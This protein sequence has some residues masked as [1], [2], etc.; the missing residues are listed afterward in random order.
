MKSGKI[1]DIMQLLGTILVY[2]VLWMP[3][4]ILV[5]MSFSNHAIGLR[6]QGFTLQWYV[7]VFNT[8]KA[9][10]ALKNSL[11][12]S[13]VTTVISTI[14]GTLAAYG[15]YKYKFRGRGAL[16]MSVLLPITIPYVVTA[17]TLLI[18]FTQ[19]ARVDWTLEEASA[20]LGADKLTTW[21]KVI[22]PVLLPAIM[23]SAALIFPW[24]FNDF[25]ITY[26]VAGVGTMTLPIYIFSL[27][28][29]SR[30]PVVINAISSVFV[31]LPII[32]LLLVTFLQRKE[33]T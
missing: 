14:G 33:T 24:S 1:A 21:R 17:A 32:G 7:Q 18:F 5:I 31:I 8:P 4:V 29:Y 13:T 3:I 19:V 28:Q 10:E 2:I 9:M 27:M 20:D 12:V 25:T 26:F 15:L 16:R 22:V 30:T 11:F 23:I 6:W